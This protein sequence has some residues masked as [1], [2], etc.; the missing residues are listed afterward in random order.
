MTQWAPVPMEVL[1]G[2][3][4][5]LRPHVEQL[6]L[7]RLYLTA[8]GADFVPM[9][10]LQVGEAPHAVWRRMW[11]SEMADAIGKLVETG[12]VSVEPVG[13]RLT[14]ATG[15]RGRSGSGGSAPLDAS[16]E[17]AEREEPSAEV[18]AARTR[19]LKFVFKNRTGELAGLDAS[20]TWEAW[21]ATSEG[22]EVFAR[23]VLGLGEATRE[24]NAT[25]TF[26]RR[27]DER[28]CGSIGTPQERHRN[29]QRNAP[30]TSSE[31]SSLKENEREKRGEERHRNGTERNAT[32]TASG[33]ATGTHHRNALDD[34]RAA[35]VGRATLTGTATLEQ[36]FGAMLSRHALTADEVTR[37]GDA[38][39]EPGAW[40][41]KGK[42]PAPTHVT[43]NDLAGFR[44]DA[45]YEW[46]PLAALVAHVRARKGAVRAPASTTAPRAPVDHAALVAE[47]EARAQRFRD[48]QRARTEPKKEVTS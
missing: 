16:D 34:L 24:R 13:L 10:P 38:F 22:R 26:R 20:L 37:A 42:N 31:T 11:G 14:I 45:G 41:P 32:G 29:G 30:L 28:S 17:R 43:L 4:V 19:K 23:R 27:S 18:I 46:R 33:T 44:G 21:L 9:P 40:W 25:G 47:E 39:N 3:L 2:P 36:E 12:L 15:M 5:R 1:D 6:A 48:A 7:V 8:R 35:S